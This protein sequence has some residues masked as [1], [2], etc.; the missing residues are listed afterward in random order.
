VFPRRWKDQASPEATDKAAGQR[1]GTDGHQ[2]PGVVA[3]HIGLGNETLAQSS[4][5]G[6]SP[7]SPVLSDRHYHDHHDALLGIPQA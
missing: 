7:M 4:V 2:H 1:V 5:L 3:Y 6:A